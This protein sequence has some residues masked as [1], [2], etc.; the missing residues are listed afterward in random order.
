M[1]EKKT[2][3]LD[4]FLKEHFVERTY[5]VNEFF[6]DNSFKDY[7]NKR[8]KI[9]PLNYDF[10]S[11]YPQPMVIDHLSMIQ[12]VGRIQRTNVG[13]VAIHHYDRDEAVKIQEKAIEMLKRM[14]VLMKE[15]NIQ[16]V[17][18]AEQKLES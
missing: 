16:Y 12:S 17:I 1:E 7:I 8:I 11:L 9:K 2:F 6:Y 5:S 14:R 4:N 18:T 10:A 13:N 3:N 15:Y